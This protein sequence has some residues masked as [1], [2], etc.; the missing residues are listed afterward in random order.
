MTWEQEG[1]L[2][3]NMNVKEAEQEQVNNMDNKSFEANELGCFYTKFRGHTHRTTDNRGI[4]SDEES[5]IEDV[6]IW[7]RK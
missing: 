5:D 1:Y 3:C 6:P 4:E 2:P 7:S